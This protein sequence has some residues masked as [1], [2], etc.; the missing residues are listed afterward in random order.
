MGFFSSKPA[1]PLA[2]SKELKRTLESLIGLDA[3][4]ALDETKA[5]LESLAHVDDMK[6]EQCLEIL[7]RL[8]EAVQVQA[9]RLGR[10]YLT[11][12]RQSRSEE[13]RLWNC[14]YSYWTQL[15]AAYEACLNRLASG[16]KPGKS[17]EALLPLFYVRLLRAY[18][19]SIKW[20]QFR[21]APM[22]AGFWLGAGRVYL[23]ALAARGERSPVLIYPNGRESTLEREYLQVLMLHSSSINGLMP[24]EVELAERLVAY[25]VPQLVFT[26]LVH[27]ANVY[28]VD[29]AKDVPPTRLARPPEITPTLR[30]LRPDA[31]LE[32]IAE[33]RERIVRDGAIPPDLQLGGQYPP[34]TVLT[35]LDHL[36][37]NWQPKPPMR[38]HQR[39]MVKSRLSVIHGLATIHDRLAHG[40]N[41]FA[42]S[43]DEEAWIAE[44]VSMGGMGAQV[45][46]GV[47]DWIAIGALIAIQPDGGDNWLV[48]M[49]RRFSR[50]D[51]RGS[52]GIQTIGKTPQAVVADGKGLH[53]ALVLLDLP[54]L[55][56]N[57]QADSFMTEVITV[58]AVLDGSA[59]EAGVPLDVVLDGRSLRLRP[60]YIIESGTGFV[61]ARF[62]VELMS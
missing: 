16:E 46:L 45:P 53:T 44:D 31:A 57:D 18:A 51:G 60:Q 8:D 7:F 21:Y 39:H 19:T 36:A 49:I 40:K 35:V 59:F 11:A 1:H 41:F 6:V 37:L 13:Y 3:A 52:V 20:T 27:P 61:I 62:Q 55:P 10:D 26:N 4:T 17:L 54:A 2:D 34:E 5:W 9:M 12:P 30:F 24:L 25:L 50:G 58:D 33:I 15:A 43:P 56:A 29:P 28:W 47:N 32:K 38:S 22:E 48:G 14:N 42:D 23:A